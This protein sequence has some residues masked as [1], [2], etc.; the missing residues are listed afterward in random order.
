MTTDVALPDPKMTIISPEGK[1][2]GIIRKMVPIAVD[3]SVAVAE[4]A[5]YAELGVGGTED[6]YAALLDGRILINLYET[7]ERSLNIVDSALVPSFTVAAARPRDTMILSRC[8]S[9]G[10]GLM[11]TRAWG[12]GAPQGE[13]MFTVGRGMRNKHYTTRRAVVPT[14]PPEI[15]RDFPEALRDRDGRFMILWEPSWE[16]VSTRR[17]RPPR[18]WD[19]ALLE[20]VEGSVY[21]VRAVWD[22]TPVEVAAL[23][24]GPRF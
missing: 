2:P 7:L 8:F 10:L 12:T 20:Q 17:P 19:P 18:N 16:V 23:L 9:T 11:Y 6:A 15:R 24:P 22:L 13:P 5:R 1:K 3:R 21:V 14:L 4:A